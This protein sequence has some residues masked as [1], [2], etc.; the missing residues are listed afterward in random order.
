MLQK[1]TM[2]AYAIRSGT[3]VFWENNDGKAYVLRHEIAPGQKERVQLKLDNAVFLSPAGRGYDSLAKEPETDNDNLVGTVICRWDEPLE[4]RF[5]SPEDLTEYLSGGP[6]ATNA[7]KD[8]VLLIARRKM[9]ADGGVYMAHYSNFSS[10]QAAIT[11]AKRV[12]RPVDVSVATAERDE[13]YH[14]IADSDRAIILRPDHSIIRM[15][16]AEL[17]ST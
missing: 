16:P 1:V 15:S 11:E 4:L 5:Q 10:E 8:Y 17:R 14:I 3:L 6:T 12:T 13:F 7:R 2:P 9:A